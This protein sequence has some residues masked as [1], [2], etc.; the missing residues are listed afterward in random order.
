M[1]HKEL[2]WTSSDGIKIYA[3]QWYVENPKAVVSIVHGMGEHSGRY[4]H[5]AKFL[6]ANGF[7]VIAFD[8]R[9]HGKSGGKRGHAPSYELLMDDISIFLE[10]TGALFPNVPV[11]LYGHSMGG[12][13]VLNYALKNTPD[14][15]GII[16]SSPWLKL[17]F[18]PPA[19]KITLAKLVNG[20]YPSLTQSS[21]LDVSAISK[22]LAEVN[23]YKTDPLVHDKISSNMFLS[24]H[25]SGL[26]A[27]ENA[28]Q[29]KA[30]LLLFHG[31]ADRITCAKASEEFVKNTPGETTTFKLLENYFHEAHNDLNKQEVLEMIKN[32]LDGRL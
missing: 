13:L 11:F 14:V 29:L 25:N 3:Q 9:G 16:A 1:D 21:N 27:I 31:T 8:Q 2:N 5:V 10:Q 15:K 24:I 22:D 26:W 6:N 32:W 18:E 17:A 20:I 28:P 30:P 23:K 19:A 12:N 4:D 7:S